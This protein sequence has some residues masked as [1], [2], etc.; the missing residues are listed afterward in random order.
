MG[1]RYISATAM[2]GTLLVVGLTQGAAWESERVV[3]WPEDA[4][5]KVVQVQAGDRKVWT[6]DELVAALRES[7]RGLPTIKLWICEDL[8]SLV[9]QLLTCHQAHPW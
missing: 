3:F 4:V 2:N 7:E 1:T 6:E 8:E 9:K 5:D